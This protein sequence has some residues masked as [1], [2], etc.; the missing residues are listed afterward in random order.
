M[1]MRLATSD[2]DADI[3]PVN[4]AR[5]ADASPEPL[6]MVIVEDDVTTREGLAALIEGTSG[7]RCSKALRSG[8]IV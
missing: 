1:F 2:R 6:R 5:G 3:A 8:S 4:G 7:Y